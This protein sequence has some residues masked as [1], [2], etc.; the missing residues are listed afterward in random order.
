MAAA[1]IDVANEAL[2]LIGS[3]KEI[4]SLETDRSNEARACNR[5]F[6]TCR[7]LVLRDFPWPRLKVVE[8]LA[9]VETDPNPQWA[10]SY[11][12]P[13]NAAQIL[14]L[15]IDASPRTDNSDSRIPYELGRDEDG[16]LIFSDYTTDDGLAAKYIYQET[17]L[18]KWT[19]DMVEVLTQLLASK[20]GPRFG[21]E[22]AK[23]AIA[24]K[25]DY[26]RRRFIARAQALNEESP[27]PAGD[28]DIVRSR[29]GG[30]IWPV[31]SLRWP[32]S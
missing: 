1:D 29:E 5:F 18:A 28:S 22:A 27:D 21:P 11:R 30:A 13:A 26:E 3:S 23:L 12:M 10:Y 7:D 32:R 31:D 9:L 17:E 6:A 20:I 8:A 24:C 2:G 14:R 16:G 25:Q 4:Q 15:Q 19:P